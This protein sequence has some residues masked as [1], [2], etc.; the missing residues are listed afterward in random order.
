MQP[1]SIRSA[2][3][4]VSDIIIDTIVE[5]I[6]TKNDLNKNHEQHVKNVVFRQYEEMKKRIVNDLKNNQNNNNKK[7]MQPETVI[8]KRRIVELNNHENIE[9]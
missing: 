6:I 8:T 3:D 7:K 2:I 4:G 9:D 5:E 1:N